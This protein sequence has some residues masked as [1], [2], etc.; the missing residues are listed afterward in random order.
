MPAEAYSVGVISHE[1]FVN[2]EFHMAVRRGQSER[3]P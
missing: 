1:L 2:A 3:G